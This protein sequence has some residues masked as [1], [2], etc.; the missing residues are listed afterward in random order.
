MKKYI[1]IFLI[2]LLILST[3]SYADQIDYQKGILDNLQPKVNLNF[4]V[5]PLPRKVDIAIDAELMGLSW[6]QVKQLVNQE[7]VPMLQAEGIDYKITYMEPSPRRWPVIIASETLVDPYGNVY[8]FNGIR[9]EGRMVYD[10]NNARIVSAANDYLLDDQGYLYQ[11]EYYA[12]YRKTKTDL[13]KLIESAGYYT[14]GLSANGKAYSVA[15][16]YPPK[17][18]AEIEGLTGIVDIAGRG[19][20]SYLA[21]TENGDVYA[22]GWGTV[23]DPENSGNEGTAKKIQG[24]SNIIDIE[25]DEYAG[26]AIDKDGYLYSWGSGNLGRTGG[27]QITRIQHEEQFTK[28]FVTKNSSTYQRYVLAKSGNL[29][30]ILTTQLRLA[31]RN[32]IEKRNGITLYADGSLNPDFRAAY[33]TTGIF[34]GY[35]RGGTFSTFNGD[36]RIWGD[37][38]P[39]WSYDPVVPEGEYIK[40]IVLNYFNDD[41]YVYEGLIVMES[42]KLYRFGGRSTVTSL[43]LQNVSFPVEQIVYVG[44]D[45]RYAVSKDGNVYVYAPW[46]TS[47][48]GQYGMGN[49]SPPFYWAQVQVSNI[50]KLVFSGTFNSYYG[51]TG[52]VIALDRNGDLWGWGYKQDALLDA[53]ANRSGFVA[54]P[55]K[56]TLPF[57]VKDVAATA[58]VVIALDTNGQVWTWGNNPDLLGHGD[59]SKTK[60]PTMVPGLPKIQALARYD[61]PDQEVILVI[62]TDQ[63]VYGWGNNSYR[64]IKPDS[65]EYRFKTPVRNDNLSGIKEMVIGFDFAMAL[66]TGGGV[67]SWGYNAGFRRTGHD[68]TGRVQTPTLILPEHFPAVNVTARQERLHERLTSVPWRTGAERYY[69]HLADLGEHEAAP[70]YRLQQTLMALLNDSIR[71]VG[72]Y[73]QDADRMKAIVESNGGN[74]KVI[75]WNDSRP[76]QTMRQIGQYII[77]KQPMDVIF[78]IGT[79][80]QDDLETVKR[81]IEKNLIPQVEQYGIELRVTLTD[82]IRIPENRLY[83]RNSS[84]NI[85]VYDPATNTHRTLIGRNVTNVS[86]HHS[87]DLYYRE[88]GTSKVYRYD[89]ERLEE[90]LYAELPD[91]ANVIDKVVVDGDGNVWY[92]TYRP[93]STNEIKK[94]DIRTNTVRVMYST[95]L[96]IGFLRVGATG[97]VIYGTT[98]SQSTLVYPVYISHFLIRDVVQGEDGCL[99][100]IYYEGGFT[101]DIGSSCTGLYMGSGRFP[102]RIFNGDRGMLFA[103]YSGWEIGEEYIQMM[104]SRGSYWV[105]IDIGTRVITT[106][107]DGRVYYEKPDDSV[108]LY[109]YN[110]RTGEKGSMPAGGI[111]GA[112]I[113]PYSFI[114]VAS[115][116]IGNTILQD[117]LAKAVWRPD[118]DAYYVYMHDGL[119]TALTNIEERLRSDRVTFIGLGTSANKAQIEH[120]TESIGDGAFFDNTDLGDAISRLA[121]YLISHAGL[122]KYDV[123]EE[124]VILE[125]VEDQRMYRSGKLVFEADYEDIENDPKVK[126]RWVFRHDPSVY[127]HPLGLLPEHGQILSAPVTILHYTGKYEVSYEAGDRPKKDPRFMEYERWS[128]TARLNIYAHRR[129][130]A[131]FTAKVEPLQDGYYLLALTDESYDIDREGAPNRGIADW[132]WRWKRSNDSSWTTGLPPSNIHERDT[133]IIALRVKDED[134]AWS[135]EKIA[136]IMASSHNNAPVARF[137]VTSLLFNDQEYTVVDQSYDPDG[138]PIAEHR[139]QVSKDGVILYDKSVLPTAATLRSLASSR[140]L[141]PFGMYTMTLTVKD[142]PAHGTPLWSEPYHQTFTIIENKPPIPGFTW[143]PTGL[144]QGNTV[145]I[146]HAINDPEKETLRVR[147]QVT[148][149]NGSVSYY[150]SS[151][152]WY[153]VAPEQYSSQAFS[154]TNLM[155]G[156]YTIVQ[157]VADSYSTRTLTKTMYVIPNRPPIAGFSWTPTVIWEGDTVYFLN[158]S[159]DP[160]GDPLTYDWTI[161]YPSGT[162]FRANSRDI[163]RRLTETGTYTVRLTVSDGKATSQKTAQ[164]EVRALALTADVQHTDLWLEYHRDAGHETERHPKDFYTGETFV[165]SANT[166]PTAVQSVHATLLATSRSGGQLQVTATLSA[167]GA[168]AYAGEMYDER[169]SNLVEGIAEGV[170]T[171]RFR[172]LY[173]NGME[174][175]TDIPVRIIGHVLE[176]VGV[177]RRQ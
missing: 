40:Q 38:D 172:V 48:A 134:G 46:A 43:Q 15:S 52:F 53:P 89:T 91:Q 163:S 146:R 128:N 32:V 168:Y 123:N 20:N 118:T 115:R 99:Y 72:V 60:T 111:T 51:Y 24:L 154:I 11:H 143:T 33:P 56:L 84:G 108:N 76:D 103:D 148:A 114:N 101:V 94:L 169:F 170:H 49:Q 127:E 28:L 5:E 104:P 71:Y 78:H 4:S 167:K 22:R 9:Y 152:S 42:G 133:Y 54:T 29:Y 173:A 95:T 50:V 159:S 74:G 155:G 62:G 37:K 10:R 18:P 87:G 139:W 80:A 41:G 75:R 157:T 21:V 79:T 113:I 93:Y 109:W 162:E 57:K 125:Y 45:V 25:F 16:T 31:D 30:E 156:N 1:I 3:S 175:T 81:L 8:R 136:V 150:P 44:G 102:E 86:I 13:V 147:Y 69:V 107:P 47:N 61:Y 100:Y 97:D 36:I 88:P 144:F 68:A 12:Y 67:Y 7:L 66:G 142:Q 138:D 145:Q 14:F 2:A 6:D 137:T 82:G 55:T 164:F 129:P 77:N 135:D 64:L 112:T 83:Y 166:S 119:I 116:K 120:F 105:D 176:T 59:T 131:D 85:A 132:Q 90:S 121:A 117:G 141:P 39:Y 171:I 158:A 153:N 110:W 73:G 140:G 149:P 19:I 161:R 65:S 106:T 122:P 130:V 174:K 160:D 177:H 151:Q 165:L 26:Y 96:N 124:K 35:F 23:F 98:G 17:P 63:R 34:A 92:S 27:A 126:E 70:G 58:G